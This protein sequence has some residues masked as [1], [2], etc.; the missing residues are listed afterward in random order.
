[1]EGSAAS[2]LAIS[3]WSRDPETTLKPAA[4]SEA[5]MLLEAV[6]LRTRMLCADAR[7]EKSAQVARAPVRMSG[8]FMVGVDLRGLGCGARRFRED[9]RARGRAEARHVTRASGT[10]HLRL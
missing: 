1:M 9:R 8:S 5:W 7:P 4:A 10:S 3:S 2:A 6:P